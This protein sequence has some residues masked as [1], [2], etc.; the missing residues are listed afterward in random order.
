MIMETAKR[1][2]GIDNSAVKTLRVAI[3]GP[4]GAGKSTVAQLVAKR[5]GLLY[6]DTGAMYRAA[7]WLAVKNGIDV[8]DGDAIAKAAGEA[9]IKL[10]PGDETSSNRV[11]VFV[12]E[13]EV[14]QAIRSHEISELVSPVSVHSPL[15]KV[16]VA[17]QKELAKRGGVVL[18]GRDIGTVVMPDADIKIYLTASTKVRAQ[19]RMKDQEALGENPDYNKL[20]AAIAERDNRDSTRADSPLK[21]ADDAIA[22]ITDNMSI[23]QV[24]DAVVRLCVGE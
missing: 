12:D 1:T 24:V 23:D 18:D 9:V 13:H 17:Q 15:R 16:M 20:V 8:K 22:I 3:D 2:D 14:T 21:Q 5:L 6:I 7:T 19:R 11:R 4:A 10:E